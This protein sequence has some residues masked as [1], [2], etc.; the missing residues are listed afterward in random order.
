MPIVL[1]PAAEPKP[2]AV[3]AAPPVLT[4]QLEYVYLLRVVMAVQVPVKPSANTPATEFPV[5]APRKEA[6][7]A[8]VALD[9]M[10]PE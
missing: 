7:V 1:F 2:E 5:A 8:A 3:V 9:T 6:V 4:T 10:H